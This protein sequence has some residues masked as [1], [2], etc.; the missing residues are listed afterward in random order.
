MS[1]AAIDIFISHGSAD[2]EIAKA[3]TYL[4]RLALNI[5]AER[6]RCT[7]VPGSGL[8]IGSSTPDQLRQDIADAKIFIGLI[9]P[10][11]LQSLYVLLEIGA[12]WG[13][14]EDL[15]L[16]LAAGADLTGLSDP[17]RSINALRCDDREHV[18]QL[19]DEIA[20]RLDTTPDSP[21]SYLGQLDELVNCSRSNPPEQKHDAPESSL[22]G[23]SLLVTPDE[24]RIADAGH[25]QSTISKRS[26]LFPGYLHPRSIMFHNVREYVGDN[27]VGERNLIPTKY[28]FAHAESLRLYQMLACEPE[29]S[30]GADGQSFVRS[31][32]ARDLLDVLSENVS[33]RG[34]LT[35]CTLGVGDGQKEDIIIRSLCRSTT[36]EALLTIEIN[37][38]FVQSSYRTFNETRM[39]F[40]FDYRFMIGD[41]DDIEQFRGIFPDNCSILFL[42]LGGTFGNQ[43]ESLFLNRL[44]RVSEGRQVFLLMDFQSTK[45]FNG[46]DKG[47]YNTLAN[48]QFIRSNIKV[49]ATDEKDDVGT[50]QI[51]ARFD[52]EFDEFRGPQRLS[53]VRNAKTIVMVSELKSGKRLFVGYSTGYEHESLQEFLAVNG[54]KFHGMVSDPSSSMSLLLCE[55]T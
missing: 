37:P 28:L 21:Q 14:R 48:K 20:R 17:F 5:P 30:M 23:S 8:P 43:P 42:A 51:E 36:V 11:S 39:K 40:G 44:K 4:L 19:V 34:R 13:S 9:T 7:T 49:Y 41:F 2:K 47:G 15:V 31:Q 10:S 32:D 27:L 52:D 6:I 33:P 50:E 16:L 24:R 38:A 45:S 12:R 46:K 35:I 3:L 26:L 55:F 1:M 29:Y 54:W 25:G 22:V 53:N 18:H